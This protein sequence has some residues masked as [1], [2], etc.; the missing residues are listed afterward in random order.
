MTP[1]SR[2]ILILG[3]LGTVVAAYLVGRKDEKK[4]VQKEKKRWST[5]PVEKRKRK[6]E[7]VKGKLEMHRDRI[8][9][10]LEKINTRLNGLAEAEAPLK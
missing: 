3:A 6:L 2:N 7:W 1:R 9:R 5:F 4:S 10:H 8:E